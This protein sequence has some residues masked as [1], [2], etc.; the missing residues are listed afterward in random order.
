M[1][2]PDSIN[3]VQWAKRGWKCVGKERVGCIGGCEKEVVIRLGAGED[4]GDGDDT[5]DEDTNGN[6]REEAE[7]QLVDRYAGMIVT[8]HEEGCLWRRKGCDSIWQPSSIR[9]DHILIVYIGTIY[10]LPLASQATAM[11]NLRDRY[12]SLAEMSSDLPSSLHTPQTFDIS[13]I[14]SQLSSLLQEDSQTPAATTADTTITEQP[15]HEALTLALFGWQAEENHISGLATCSAC[16]RR[17]GLWLFKPRPAS[18]ASNASGDTEP[19][20][21]RLDVVAEHRDYCPWINADSQGRGH[22]SEAEPGWKILLRVVQNAS[23]L[24]S[25]VLAPTIARPASASGTG[26]GDVNEVASMISSV[27]TRAER[28]EKDRER[29]AKLKRLKKAFTVKGSKRLGKGKEKEK[30]KENQDPAIGSRPQSIAR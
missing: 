19:S 29:F 6:W 26:D 30:E 18:S 9:S 10:R 5:G 21:T 1:A 2:K 13:Q 4:L 7:R 12:H 14:S 16:F 20:M 11:T 27:E 24:M 17:L 25:D 8:E 22:T 3:E 28:D 23:K 15:N